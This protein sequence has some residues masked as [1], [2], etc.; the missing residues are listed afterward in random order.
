MKNNSKTKHNFLYNRRQEI[1]ICLF[2]IASSLVVYEQIINHEFINYDDGLYVTENPHVQA[3]FTW[4]SIKWALTTFHAGNWHP[5][6][7]FSHMLDCELYGLNPMG[8]HWTNLQFH[9]ANTL[10]LFFILQQMTGAFWKS[11]FV[12]ALFAL[13]PLHVE[14]VA[15]VT[16]RKDVLSTFFGF[17]VII[18]YYR[19]V[20][21]PDIAG[22]MLIFLS[23]SLGLMAKPMLV[24]MPFV[25]LLLDLWP[26]KRLN[27]SLNQ[28]DGR[29]SNLMPLIREKIPLII[30]ATISI[31]LTFFAQQSR[32]AVQPLELIPINYRIANALI[33]YSGYFIKT[34]WP[35]NMSVFYPH[36]GVN[37]PMWEVVSSALFLIGACLLAIKASKKYP[38]MLVGLLWYII[39]LIPVIGLIQVGSQSMADRYTYI[40]LIGIFIILSWGGS[41]FLKSQKHRNCVLYLSALIII[42][43][44]TFMSFNQVKHWKNSITLFENSITVTDGNWLAHNNLGAALFDKEKIDES[45]FHFKEVLKIKPVY[46][47][48]LYNLGRSF[49]EKSDLD[50]AAYYYKNALRIKP[51]YEEAHNNLANLLFA[52]GMLDE[53]A[54]HYY[55]ILGINPDNADVHNNLGYLLVTEDK[56][57]EALLHFNEALRINPEHAE[58][59]Y[60]LGCLMIKQGE[61]EEAIAH[62]VKAL[63][64][65]YFKDVQK[66][67]PGY[68]EVYNKIGKILYKNGKLKEA[69]IFFSKAIQIEPDCKEARDNLLILKKMLNQDEK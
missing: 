41:D 62:F 6:T 5:L 39:T 65:L 13:H 34:I 14:S 38:Y 63:S 66:I 24:T 4:E 53:A 36:L 16:E 29:T 23:L 30:L 58:A 12:A 3:G 8:H 1:I 69:G 64:V 32:G 27:L 15:W 22:Y 21:K 11:A 43:A 33:A 46:F 25:L 55:L 19:Y 18:T 28:P 61:T 44:F 48:A 10:L 40:P 56:R 51:D 31:I 17:L 20:K 7:W 57:K 35:H 67:N 60:N 52:Q 49:Q 45:I 47:S 37:Q 9:I 50:K 59:H 54:S 68:A 2:L 42:S 26:L